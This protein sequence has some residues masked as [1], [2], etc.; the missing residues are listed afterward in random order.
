MLLNV[1]VDP[2][3]AR[4]I[5]VRRSSCL[6]LG[7]VLIQSDKNESGVDVYMFQD[8]AA[9]YALQ[10]RDPYAETYPNIYDGPATERF[11]GQGLATSDKL[12]FGFPYTPLSLALILPG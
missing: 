7:G 3:R 2:V 8:K 12:E 6:L 4:W 11:Y 10:D 5:P 9:S 1:L